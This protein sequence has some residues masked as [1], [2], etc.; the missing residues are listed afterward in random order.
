LNDQ[1]Y[2][3]LRWKNFHTKVDGIISSLRRHKDIVECHASLTQYHL[4]QED[5]AEFKAKLEESVVREETKELMVVKQWLAVGELP[6][7]D[8]TSFCKIRTECATTTRWILE[9]ETI[10]HWVHADIRD[11]PVV[12]MY[13]I[14]GAGQYIRRNSLLTLTKDRQDHTGIGYR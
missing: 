4:Y 14:P 5:V 13:E 3:T 7:L 9:H 1:Q 6:Q 2:P 10:K 11:G 12:W 8:H